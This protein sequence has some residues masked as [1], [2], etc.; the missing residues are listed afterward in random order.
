MTENKRFYFNGC[1]NCIEFD[2]KSI[3]CDSYGDELADVMND[4]NNKNENLI[5]ISAMTQVKNDKLKEE[6]ERLEK[7]I[8]IYK[9]T[10]KEAIQNERTHLGHNALKQLADNLGVEV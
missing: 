4:L 8:H 10:L 2:G 7:K 5:K 1:N 3:L 9:T 6:N